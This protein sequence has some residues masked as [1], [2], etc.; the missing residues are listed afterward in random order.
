MQ[1]QDI[2]VWNNILKKKNKCGSPVFPGI[3][4]V[5]CVHRP[6]PAYPQ[7]FL[8]PRAGDRGVRNL[9]LYHRFEYLSS[10]KLHKVAQKQ[11]PIF[12][13]HYPLHFSTANVIIKSSKRGNQGGIKNEALLQILYEHRG[14]S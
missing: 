3:F 5:L 6:T 8:L 1:G 4:Q 7:F 2:E 13:Q 9:Q 11:I 14:N 10:E 12:V